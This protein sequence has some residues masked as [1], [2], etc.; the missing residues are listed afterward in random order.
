MNSDSLS[1]LLQKWPNVPD[2]FNWLSLDRRGTWRIKGSPITNPTMI[3]AI[4][5][6]YFCD[7]DGS[8]FFQNGPQ[9]V[10]VTLDYTPY[11]IFAYR[12]GDEL[13]LKTHSGTEI[14]KIDEI[15]LDSDLNFLITWDGRLGIISDRDLQILID[16]MS[17]SHQGKLISLENVIETDT[18]RLSVTFW[19]HEAKITKV[20]REYLL[21]KFNIRG[22]PAPR[23]G[24][25]DC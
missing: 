24:Q 13:K 14:K 18:K 2:V 25:P 16:G 7:V 11:V 10:F 21:K 20:T 22:D 1:K 3:K 5:S 6:S 19:N 9:K 17:F 8:W 15:Y 4:N 12:A 23:P